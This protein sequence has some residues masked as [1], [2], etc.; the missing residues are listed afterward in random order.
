[1]VAGVRGSTM[2]GLN[3]DVSVNQGQ[4]QVQ[5]FIFDTVN[6]SLGPDSPTRFEPNLLEQTETTFN[7]DLSYAAS[8]MINVAGGAE[9][10]NEQYQL[11]PAIRR[12]G[13]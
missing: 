6:A 2:T 11:G 10:R 4:N 5:T 9:W 1:M 7:A 8:D 3:W 12:R 13:R